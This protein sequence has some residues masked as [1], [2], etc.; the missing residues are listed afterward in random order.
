MIKKTLFLLMLFFS[1]LFLIAC[2]QAGDFDDVVSDIK[3]Q[4]PR[5]VNADFV[6]PQTDEATIEWRYEGEWLADRF[7][8]ESPFF[9]TDT[10]LVATIRI[11]FATETVR[12]PLTLVPLESAENDNRIDIQMPITLDQLTRET[13]VDADIRIHTKK[14]GRDVLEHETTD[15]RVR[16]RGNSTWFM[17]KKPLRIRFEDKTSILGLPKA[18]KYV[19][20]AEYSDKS[21]LRNTLVHKFSG[22]LDHIEHAISTRTVEL[23]VNGSYEGVYTLAEQVEVYDTKLAVEVNPKMIDTGYFLEI[24]H[25]FYENNEQEGREWFLIEGIPYQVKEPEMEE[26]FYTI[27]HTAFIQTVLREVE[28][29]LIRKQGYEDV[30]DLDN[31]IDYFLVQELF[32]NVDVGFSS[33]FIY[34]QPAGKIK[35]GPLWDFD[36]A[37]GNADYIDYGPEN[38]YGMLPYKNRW[39]ELMMDIP[40]VRE[41]FRLRYKEVYQDAVRPLLQAIPY[42]GLQMEEKAERNFER[43][44]ILDRYVWPNPQP[45]VLRQTY[46]EQVQYVRDYLTDRALWLYYAIDG[47]R[48]Q[49]GRFD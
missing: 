19:L 41:R 24:D 45:V 49:S 21:L 35:L 6:L 22:L 30:I 36:L 43:W 1:A 15:V 14:N 3:E 48:Y 32:K 29:A 18:K 42:L 9:V 7:V 38:F 11:G 46:S 4:L 31:W 39:F 44:D 47:D 10:E 17:P 12:F 23:Y 40:D 28:D 33:V 13:Y 27:E 37:L 16:G 2:D 26:P 20:L 8:F 25:R 5:L 34:R